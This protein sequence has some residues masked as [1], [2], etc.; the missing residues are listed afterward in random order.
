MP[1]FFSVSAIFIAPLSP[2]K[3]LYSLHV[4]HSS[5]R[6]VLARPLHTYDIHSSTATSWQKGTKLSY[7]SV[8]SETCSCSAAAIQIPPASPIELCDSLHRLRSVIIRGCPHMLV[9]SLPSRTQQVPGSSKGSMQST[10]D[11][12]RALSESCFPSVLQRCLVPPRP[13]S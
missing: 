3:L 2:T 7:F 6:L 5:A 13:Q 10:S 9:P 4:G 11:P 12:T 8:V 1:L